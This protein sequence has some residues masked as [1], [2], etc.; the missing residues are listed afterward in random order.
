MSPELIIVLLF[1][2]LIVSLSVG[3]PFAFT[4]GGVG[5]IFIYFA[6]KPQAVY[7]IAAEGFSR[8][9]SFAFLACALFIFM[10]IVL[11]KSGLADA[12]F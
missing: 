1:V 7:L 4:L 5:I 10:G 3:V 12:I 9:T 11:E 2:C 6:W 8:L